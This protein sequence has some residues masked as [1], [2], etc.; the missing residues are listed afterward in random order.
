MLRLAKVRTF[1]LQGRCTGGLFVLPLVKEEGPFL[2]LW[3]G[4]LKYQ[5]DRGV[6]KAWGGGPGRLGSG[7]RPARAHLWVEGGKS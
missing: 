7:A 1:G 6:G 2:K 3:F 5:D 4:T